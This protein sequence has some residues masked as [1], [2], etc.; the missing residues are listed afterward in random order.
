[1]CCVHFMHKNDS[2]FDSVDNIFGHTIKMP[3]KHAR[4]VHRNAAEFHL[5]QRGEAS[6][7]GLVGEGGWVRGGGV[8]NAN[9]PKT[10]EPGF[11]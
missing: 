5:Q 3:T 8:R 1:M 9:W 4:A 11:G 6:G 7:G 10:S 2:S